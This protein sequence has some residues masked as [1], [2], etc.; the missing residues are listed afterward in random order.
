MKNDSS[1][2]TD[3]E[4]KPTIDLY[5]SYVARFNEAVKK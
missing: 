5:N 3:P 1:I 2:K 4:A